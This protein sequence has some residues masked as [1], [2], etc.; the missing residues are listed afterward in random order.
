MSLL[1]TIFGVEGPQGVSYFTDRRK[2]LAEFIRQ[3][4]RHTPTSVVVYKALDTRA[5][6]LAVLNGRGWAEGQSDVTEI[7]LGEAE[8]IALIEAEADADEEATERSEVQK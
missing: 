6:L 8:P 5:T 3:R 1:M 2:A 7:W 4:E